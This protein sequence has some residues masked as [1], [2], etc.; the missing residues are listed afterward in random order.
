MK[1]LLL[2]IIFFAV[3]CGQIEQGPPG[4]MGPQGLNGA[5]GQVGA[6]G[7]QGPAGT[8]GTVVTAVQLCPATFTPVYPTEFPESALCVGGNLYGVYSANGGFLAELPPGQYSSDGINASC[9][10]T[11]EAN[12]V[13]VQQ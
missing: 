11:I 3:G 8:P 9:T 10:F 7:P 4:P 2:L 13:V 6:Q 5:T 12:C 1:T